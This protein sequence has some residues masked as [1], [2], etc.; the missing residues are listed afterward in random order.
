MQQYYY[1]LLKTVLDQA[2]RQ[3][4]GSGDHLEAVN[5]AAREMLREAPV[6]PRALDANELN[7]GINPHYACKTV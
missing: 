3:S 2:N 7:L 1:D 4:F 5:H 6:L